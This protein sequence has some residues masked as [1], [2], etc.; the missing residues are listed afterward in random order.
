MFEP[1]HGGPGGPGCH[2]RGG[3]FGGPMFEAR[4]RPMRPYTRYRSYLGTGISALV[5]AAVGTSIANRNRQSV[6]SNNNYYEVFSFCPNC[7]T[8]RSG[9]STT[10]CNCGGSLI[11]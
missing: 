9:N 4:P 5:G 11:K 8:Q 6:S 7:G 10:C 3:G 1:R 2:G